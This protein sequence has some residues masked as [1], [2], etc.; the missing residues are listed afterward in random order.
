MLQRR[1]RYF[2]GYKRITSMH[3]IQAVGQHGVHSS[4]HMMEKQIFML[5]TKLINALKDSMLHFYRK[6]FVQIPI[7]F[8]IQHLLRIE[9]SSSQRISSQQILFARNC[10]RRYL[11]LWTWGIF[12]FPICSLGEKL[13]VPDPLLL[14]YSSASY[15]LAQ[16]FSLDSP[17]FKI[18]LSFAA[19]SK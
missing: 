18:S 2:N 5:R 6:T 9:D 8:I 12:M 15:W 4:I 16:V 1:K 3:N 10:R 13:A 11:Q 14:L 7:F 19:P 17:R